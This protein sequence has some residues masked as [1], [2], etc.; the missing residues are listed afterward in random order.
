MEGGGRWEVEKVEGG[1]GGRWLKVVFVE[2]VPEDEGVVCYS[3]CD[4]LWLKDSCACQV[5]RVPDDEGV[6]RHFVLR[7]LWVKVP[8]VCRGESTGRRMCRS[9]FCF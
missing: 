7:V 8:C 5:A 2:N 3:V 9:L 4:V 6:V 1:E